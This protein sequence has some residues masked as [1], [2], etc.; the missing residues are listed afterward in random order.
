M[1]KYRFYLIILLINFYTLGVAQE[2]AEKNF[3]TYFHKIGDSLYNAGKL[4]EI[5]VLFQKLL[6]EFPGKKVLLLTKSAHINMELGRAKE[7]LEFYLQADKEDG[8]K[9]SKIAWDLA[10]FYFQKHDLENTYFW[11]DASIERGD[12][13]YNGLAQYDLFAP[14]KDKA[15]F[16]ALV[17][18]AKLNVGIG[19]DVLPVEGLDINGEKISLGDYNG[20]VVLIDFWATWCPPC[21]KALPNLKNL[22]NEYHEKGFEIIGINLDS[23]KEY[24]AKFLKTRNIRWS[25][26]YNGKGFND[27]KLRQK[28]SVQYVP[29]T[30]LIDR[31][32]KLRHFQMHKDKFAQTIAELL[33]ER[34]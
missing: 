2:P 4:D 34:S 8:E 12:Y 21:I 29:S 25:N 5:L 30:Y 15:Q 24:F 6:S 17:N 22:Y 27:D 11:L 3:D 10:E 13:D 33:V 7:A 14:I 26:I 19:K 18:K 31:K 20:K 1:N 32:G 28:F 23:N 16:L 9:S